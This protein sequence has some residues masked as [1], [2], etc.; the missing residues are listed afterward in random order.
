MKTK[1]LNFEVYH[2]YCTSPFRLVV[3]R[4]ISLYADFVTEQFFPPATSTGPHCYM[5]LVKSTGTNAK[6]PNACFPKLPSL[7]AP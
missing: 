3:Y 4:S 7:I 2:F 1:D 5:S 6:L